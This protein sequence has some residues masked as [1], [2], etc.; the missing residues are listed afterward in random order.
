MMAMLIESFAIDSVWTLG[1]IICWALNKNGATAEN[2]GSAAS[3][4]VFL[5]NVP[6][7]RVSAPD[8]FIGANTT[9][10]QFL[11]HVVAL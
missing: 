9:L 3:A 2:V 5:D 10:T 6:Y 7:I 11:F 8:Y 1:I 4:L